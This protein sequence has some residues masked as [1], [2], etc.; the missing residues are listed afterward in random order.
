MIELP[1][2]G[3]VKTGT[4]A[5]RV[6]SMMS[7]DKARSFSD[8]EVESL[9]EAV[10]LKASELREMSVADK[11]RM[12]RLVFCSLRCELEILQDAAEDPS[13]SE[14]MVNGPDNIFLERAGRMERLNLAFDSQSQ[15]ERVIQRLAARVGREMN[16]LNP[17]VDA[18]LSDGSRINA[19]NSNIAIDGPVLTIRRFGSGRLSME[20]IISSGGISEEA[21]D[22]LQ[23]L[24]RA[25]YNIFISGGTSSGKSTFL[26][27]L[28]D[29]IPAAE[30][31]IVIEDSA[32]LVIRNHENLVR[33]EAKNANAQG[34]GAVSIRELIKSSLRMRPDRIIVGEVRGEE[35]VDMLAAMSTGHDGS[36]STGHANSPRGML[37]RLES[38][39]LASSGFPIEAVRGQIAEAIDI[40]VHLSRDSSGVR[41]ITEIAELK[42]LEAGELLLNTLFRYS[43]ETGLKRVG[44]LLNTEK[45]GLYE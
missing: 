2:A 44:E 42:G 4:Y 37:R 43:P 29:Y 3:P 34:K 22:F 36:L 16:E 1:P 7:E 35:V 17:I 5:D 39:F 27:V 6:R 38:L 20:D 28:S 13:V 25:R 18:R 26:N 9:C 19:V 21:A 41:R 10:V 45:L 11:I 23:R 33:L 32:E 30:R 31:I 40:F 12:V 14:I 15:L 8:E 24:V